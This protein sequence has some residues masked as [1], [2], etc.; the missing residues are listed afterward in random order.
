MDEQLCPP[1]RV[2]TEFD[3]NQA[4][5]DLRFYWN[6]AR[7]KGVAFEVELWAKRGSIVAPQEDARLVVTREGR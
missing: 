7:H 3:L 1:I 6:L 5:S 2:E 4:I